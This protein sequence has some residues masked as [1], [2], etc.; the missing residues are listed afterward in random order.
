MGEGIENY[1]ERVVPYG[2]AILAAGAVASSVIKY[3][4][5]TSVRP[6]DEKIASYLETT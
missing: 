4:F 3:L 2:I 6:P 5:V 1:I